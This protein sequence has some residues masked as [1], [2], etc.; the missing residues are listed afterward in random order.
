MS[1]MEAPKPIVVIGSI[2]MDLVSRVD[3]RPRAGETVLG[4]DFATLHGGK[5]ANQAVAAA[6]LDGA[7]HMIG[8]VGDDAFGRDLLGELRKNG[9]GTEH[10]RVSAGV[11]SGVAVIV[12]DETGENSII[13]T[14][15][16][17]GRLTPADIDAAEPI[18]AGAVCVMLQL[19]TPQETIAHAI[20]L[21]DGWVSARFWILLRLR[22]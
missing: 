6:R 3:R 14:P 16:A 19:E 15:G 9:V 18:I 7:V 22:R 17:N 4:R 1:N 5:G 8:R 2:N 11:S 13:V 10:V 21:A 20:E 12:V